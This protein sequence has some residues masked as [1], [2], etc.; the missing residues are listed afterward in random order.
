MNPQT[1]TETQLETSTELALS[2]TDM[3]AD[4]GFGAEEIE[5]LFSDAVVSQSDDPE[6]GVFGAAAT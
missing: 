6:R 4:W 5:A 3:L 2:E 1:H